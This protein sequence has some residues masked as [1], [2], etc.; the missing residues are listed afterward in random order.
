MKSVNQLKSNLNEKSHVICNVLIYCHTVTYIYYIQFI[1]IIVS[2]RV[3]ISEHFNKIPQKMYAGMFSCIGSPKLRGPGLQRATA[4]CCRPIQVTER[5]CLRAEHRVSG[6]MAIFKRKK[7]KKTLCS[8]DKR[9][10]ALATKGQPLQPAGLRT[11]PRRAAA[12]PRP[13]A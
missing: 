2:F 6:F 8:P 1:T 12:P 9:C 11:A 3:V 4:A 5:A 13:A 10:R 7:L